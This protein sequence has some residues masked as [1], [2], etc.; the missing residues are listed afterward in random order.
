MKYNYPKPTLIAI[1]SYLAVPLL[2]LITLVGIDLLETHNYRSNGPWIGV[3]DGAKIFS[4]FGNDTIVTNLA[5]GDS[6]K[7]LGII[8]SPKNGRLL[9]ETAQGDRGALYYWWADIDLITSNPNLRGDTI[10]INLPEKLK[11]TNYGLHYGESH[12]KGILVKNGQTVDIDR[13]H[14]YPVI[15]NFERYELQERHNFSKIMSVGK[16]K[17]LV[18][19]LNLSDA[20]MKIGPMKYIARNSSDDIEV[21]FRTYIFNPE[22]GKFYNPIITFGS[23]SVAT[24]SSLDF[25][26]DRSSWVLK[27]LPLTSFIY[28]LPITSFLTRTGVYNESYLGPDFAK[29]GFKKVLDWVGTFFAAILGLMWVFVFG[30][31]PLG[32]IYCILH[33]PRIL[34]YLSDMVVVGIMAVLTAV[35]TYYWVIALLAWG[36]YWWVAVLIIAASYYIWY[37]YAAQLEDVVPHTRCQICRA[38]DSMELIESEFMG[39]K[40]GTE[41][42]TES[43][44]IGRTSTKTREW[45]D[46]YRGNT[47]VREENSRTTIDTDTTYRDD[48]YKEKVRYDNYK[49]HYRCNVCGHKER[50]GKTKRNVLSRHYQGSSTH[51][52]RTTQKYNY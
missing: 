7:V 41:N 29:N 3:R 49:L 23:D 50:T 27:Y 25:A 9:V 45:T 31:V 19:G 21:R 46:V 39:S 20:E 32:I 35:F 12:P 14:Y 44:Q 6:V 13:Y 16:M 2:I 36:A 38:M 48:H 11:Q 26:T 34:F 43:T 22:D 10:R 4:Y 28:D 51:T 33:Y 42:R 17:K 52:E 1:L 24:A 18:D 37:F 30:A 8:D 40:H 5:K 15:K 47:K